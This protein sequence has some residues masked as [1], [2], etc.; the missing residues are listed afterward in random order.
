MPEFKPMSNLNQ[1]KSVFSLLGKEFGSASIAQGQ[2]QPDDASEHLLHDAV[3][4]SFLQNPWFIPK[5]VRFSFK[6]WADALQEDKLAKW[7]AQYEPGLMKPS[8]PKT[9]GMVMAGNIP[10]VGLHDL[11]CVLSAGHNALIKLSGND[12]ELMPAVIRFLGSIG[13]GL[14][15]RIRISDGP[16]KGFDAAIATGSNNSSRYFDYYFG[17]FPSIIRK[18][19]NGVAVL[20]GNESEDELSG[21]ADDI[22]MYFGL[23]CR[24]VSKLY[25]PEG[26]DFRK[27]LDAFSRYAFL[28][29]LHKYRNNYDYQKSIFIINN[30]PHLDNGFLLV[31]SDNT[32]ISPISVIHTHTYPGNEALKFDLLTNSEQ[33]QCIV[34]NDRGIG[35]TVPFGKSQF[36]ELWDYADGVD[37]MDFL[38]NL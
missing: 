10:L 19:R 2:R 12:N 6:A 9:V 36:P 34:A 17:R 30:I 23:G 33:I 28:A 11:L 32:F 22:F 14:Q 18:N 8:Q 13:P 29:D 21:L 27:L 37:T 26:Y 25:V 38:L 15:D 16:L 20:N 7:I 31:K 35:D 24:S 3:E 4:R 5:F 1:L